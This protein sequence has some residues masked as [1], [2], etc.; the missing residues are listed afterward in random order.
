MPEMESF[1]V[2]EIAEQPVRYELFVGYVTVDT[3]I[4]KS[5]LVLPMASVQFVV[6]GQWRHPEALHL[7]MVA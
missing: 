6:E 5:I 2:P 7:P 1:A 3:G 4:V